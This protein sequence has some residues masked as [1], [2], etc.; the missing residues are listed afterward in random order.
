[1]ETSASEDST[2]PEEEGWDDLDMDEEEE[3][4][5]PESEEDIWIGPDPLNDSTPDSCEETEGAESLGT[6]ALFEMIL[7]KILM[8]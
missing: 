7:Q 8:I 4:R 3:Q 2:E 5:G 1:M 6:G